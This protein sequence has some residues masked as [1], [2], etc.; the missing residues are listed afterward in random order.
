VRSGPASCSPGPASGF[1]A[2]DSVTA[3]AGD[4]RGMMEDR[5]PSIDRLASDDIAFTDDHGQQGCAAGRAEIGEQRESVL[6][7]TIP[8]EPGGFRHFCSLLGNRN[9]TELND[10]FADETGNPAYRLFLG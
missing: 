5:T 10:R 9:I 2:H 6:A 7:V 3:P 4:D 1:W 8:E